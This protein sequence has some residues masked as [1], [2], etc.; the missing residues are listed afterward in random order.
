M[1]YSQ[2]AEGVALSSACISGVDHRYPHVVPVSLCKL[3]RFCNTGKDSRETVRVMCR[4]TDIVIQVLS[5][6]QTGG[7][8][9]K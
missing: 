5:T 7:P 8:F 1:T 3:F 9:I 6:F 4:G 2:R